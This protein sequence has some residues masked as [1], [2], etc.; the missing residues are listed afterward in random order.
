MN[1]EPT[2]AGAPAPGL[3]DLR[4]AARLRLL[5]D[6]ERDIEPAPRFGDFRLT[7]AGGKARQLMGLIK[8]HH[9]RARRAT[10]PKCAIRLSVFTPTGRPAVFLSV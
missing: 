8:A 1:A 3:E 7:G 5:R 2:I 9:A 4:Q 6:R 10:H